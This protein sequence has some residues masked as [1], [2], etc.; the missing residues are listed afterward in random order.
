MLL[1][2]DMRLLQAYVTEGSEEAF[3]TILDRHVNL[4]YSTALRQVGDPSLANEV[5]QTTF[6]ILARKAHRLGQG[7]ILAGWLYRTAQFAATRALRT[8][9]RRRERE[10][11]AALMQTETSGSIWEQLS[12]ILD[13]A[14]ADLGATDRN[15]LVLRYFENKTAKDVGLALGLNEAAAQK[16]LVRAIE[17]LRIFCTK[18]GVVLSGV[19]LAGL[20]SANAVQ[21]APVSVTTAT[22]AALHV[23]ALGG[24]TGALTTGTLKLI[25]W[26]RLKIAMLTGLGVTTVVLGTVAFFH[27]TNAEPRYQDRVLTSWLEQLDNRQDN[28][29]AVLPWIS[30]QSQWQPSAKQVEAAEAIRAMGTSAV[31]SLIA[32]LEKTNLSRFDRLFGR[33]NDL[34]EKNHR[35]AALALDALGPVCKPWVPQ[36]SRILYQAQCPKEA[37]VALAAI[38]PEGWDVLTKATTAKGDTVACA[39]WALGSHHITAPET[40]DALMASY[41]RNYPSGMEI[42]SLWALME[43]GSDH[44]KLIPL[45]TEGLHSPRSDMRWGSAVLLGR[46]G[47]EAGNALPALWLALQ[48]KDPVVRHDAAQ[49]IE[50]IDPQVAAQANLPDALANIHVPKTSLF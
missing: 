20:L 6:I 48:D 38:G 14:M 26:T 8:E 2:E 17:K 16:R 1:M 37:A 13:Q 9:V 44:Q 15:A 4:V 31:P 21:S 47:P 43:I 19:A 36:L 35:K 45:L 22:A 24:S 3:K 27:F 29:S 18:K 42:V 34:I 30:W 46:L 41:E 32:A 10:R 33:S 12:P 11:E 49:A 39:I 25:A 50:Q 28:F 23:G 5:T 40:E 7:T